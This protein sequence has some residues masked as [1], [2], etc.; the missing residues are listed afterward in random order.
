MFSTGQQLCPEIYIGKILFMTNI[1]SQQASNDWLLIHLCSRH[2]KS[3]G[4][5]KTLPEFINSINRSLMVWRTIGLPRLVYIKALRQLQAAKIHKEISACKQ[6]QQI[7][8]TLER[9]LKIK[10]RK[11][12]CSKNT[13]EGFLGQCIFIMLFFSLL[14]TCMWP[15]KCCKRCTPELN[16]FFFLIAILF[17]FD[18]KARTLHCSCHITN[19]AYKVTSKKTGKNTTMKESASKRNVSS[20]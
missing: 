13:G 15:N 12:V 17:I 18:W 3:R 7:K 19:K 1:Q 2:V 11:Y 9:S 14:T 4:C 6:L 5:S 10:E 8:K 20:T 16:F